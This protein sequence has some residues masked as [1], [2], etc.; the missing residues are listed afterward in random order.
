MRYMLLIASDDKTAAPLPKAEME[1]RFQAHARFQQELQAKGKMVVGERLRPDADAS[2]VRL[3]AGQ[4]QVTDGPFAET[5]EALG[6]FY[7]IECETKQEAIEWA[8]KIPL[9][10]GSFVEVRPI[11]PM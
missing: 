3:K 4:P 2:R 1:A 10:D 7:L 6:G 11:W 8:K 5:K 9:G